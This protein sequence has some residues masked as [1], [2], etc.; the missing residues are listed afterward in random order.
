MSQSK[1]SYEVRTPKDSAR[2]RRERQ[3]TNP[4]TESVETRVEPA[5][6][7]RAVG[8]SV[9]KRNWREVAYDER[10]LV[11]YRPCAWPECFPDG[12]P[13]I[14]EIETVIRSTHQPTVYHRPRNTESDQSTA[15]GENSDGAADASAIGH[16]V[17]TEAIT[18]IAE[19]REGDRVVWEGQ[20]TPMRVD[21]S[22]DE[23]GVVA[24][25]GP[26]GGEYH[27]E[28]R[29]EVAQPYYVSPCYGYQSAIGRLV[30]ADDQSRPEAV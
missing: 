9:E 29:P 28:E 6:R 1:P 27:I 2:T 7:S 17:T 16:A 22:A 24:L 5:C 21:G 15:D 26:D 11:S 30:P 10:R 12:A 8:H 3:N 14:T 13:D 4:D 23:A 25:S 20:S 19:L 18:T